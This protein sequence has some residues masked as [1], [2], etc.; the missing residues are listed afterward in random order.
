MPLIADWSTPFSR[1]NRRIQG[2]AWLALF[3]PAATAGLA[4]ATA[5]FCVCQ[6]SL[7]CQ[8]LATGVGI[9]ARASGWGLFVSGGAGADG[10]EQ[11]VLQCV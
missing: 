11:T 5:D 8:P 3:K 4:A 9:D 10:G 1:S 2:I 6:L 7:C